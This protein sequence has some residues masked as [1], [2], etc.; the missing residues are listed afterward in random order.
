ML[1]TATNPT[2]IDDVARLF[3]KSA[4]SSFDTMY[5]ILSSEELTKA[6]YAAIGSATAA[7]QFRCVEDDADSH[8]SRGA[9]LYFVFHHLVLSTDPAIN[10]AVLNKMVSDSDFVAFMQALY[11]VPDSLGLTTLSFH[12]VGTTS[13]IFKAQTRQFGVCA[14]KVIQAPYTRLSAIATATSE[15]RDRY[16][17]H[18]EHCPSIHI[19]ESGWMLMEF[20]QGMNLSAFME[21]LRRDSAFMSETYVNVISSILK[22][23]TEALSYYEAPAIALPHGDLNPFNIMI[24]GPVSG[25]TSVKLIDFGPNYVLRDRV[26]STKHFAQAYSRTE[27]FVA[28][29]VLRGQQE[30]STSA[31]LYSLGMIALELVSRAPL[32][33]DAVSV[34]MAEVWQHPITN[35]I[36]KVIEDLIDDDPRNRLLIISPQGEGPVY[37]ALLE[38]LNEQTALYRDMLSRTNVD[39][40]LKHLVSLLKFDIVESLENMIHLYQNSKTLYNKIPAVQLYSSA[41]R[42]RILRRASYMPL[43]QQRCICECEVPRIGGRSTPA[44]YG[45]FLQVW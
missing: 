30:P 27:L 28:P 10:I 33:R 19:S 14:F 11:R 5:Y 25:P 3:Q 38:F 36:A 32:R 7:L 20:V 21:A 17:L 6:H 34:R 26:G 31:D 16:G 18:T 40:S 23:I 12:A 4:T 37:P 1:P 43:P 22:M 29:E 41:A 9:I 15:Y 35:G 42:V 24:Q 2:N 45:D 8:L 39:S 13:F 44:C